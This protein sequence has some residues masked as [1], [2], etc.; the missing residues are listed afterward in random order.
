VRPA[1]DGVRTTTTG[2]REPGQRLSPFRMLRM[3]EACR[4]PGNRIGES[5]AVCR[6]PPH[7]FLL[8]LLLLLLLPQSPAVCLL[9]L[10]DDWDQFS[11]TGFLFDGWNIAVDV[12]FTV[13]WLSAALQLS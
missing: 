2:E 9:L 8:L 1:G 5:F 10:T 13:H 4:T 12:R 11:A 6:P 3:L 7:P